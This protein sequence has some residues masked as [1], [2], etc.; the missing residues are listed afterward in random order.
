MACIILMLSM[1]AQA[2]IDESDTV[3][4]RMRI[5]VGGNRQTGNVD[6]KAVRAKVDFGHAIG[7]SLYFKTQNNYLYQEFFGFKADQDLFN[8]NYLYFK[9]E[10]RLYP[11]AIAYYSQNYRRKLDARYFAGVGLTY[12]LVFH[13]Q[14]SV[15]LSANGVYEVSLFAA[16]QYNLAAYDGRQSVEVMRSTIY[17][18]GNHRFS[19]GKVH[20]FYDYYWQPAW[21]DANNY[22]SQFDIG[23]DWKLWRGLSM[24]TAYSYT[25]E[26]LVVANVRRNDGI[27]VFGLSFSASA[28]S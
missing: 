9:P 6:Y 19:A 13:P 18:S 22:R 12:Q 3:R 28:K 23:I 11:Y 17:I 24:N 1:T 16:Q 21:D 7:Q 26:N 14:H 10:G 5:N 20:L 8:R 15:K 4:Y 2:Q 27:F 25:H